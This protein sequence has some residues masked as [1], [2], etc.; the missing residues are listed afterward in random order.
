MNKTKKIWVIIASILLPVV[1]AVGCIVGAIVANGNKDDVKNST[2]DELMFTLNNQISSSSDLTNAIDDMQSLIDKS[3]Y[4]ISLLTYQINGQINK[5]EVIPNGTQV[6]LIDCNDTEKTYFNGWR[7]NGVGQSYNP[8]QVYTVQ[9]STNFVANMVNKA[10]VTFMVDGQVSNTE[11][12]IPGNSTSL[13]QLNDTDTHYFNGW[14][15]DDINVTGRNGKYYTINQDVTV[16]AEFLEHPTVVYQVSGEVVKEEQVNYGTTITLPIQEDTETHYYVGWKING[17][18][19]AYKSYTIKQDITFVLCMSEGDFVKV[20]F[21][22]EG[23]TVGGK[24]DTWTDGT[25]IYCK[26]SFDSKNY[27]LNKETNTWETI[28]LNGLTS[29]FYPSNVWTDGENTYYSDASDQYKLN[30]ET[31]TWEAM[32]WNGLTSFFGT[33]IWTDGENIYHSND[34][35]QYILN[36]ETHTWEAMSWNGLTS[37]HGIYIWTDGE[38]IYY[39]YSYGSVSNQYILKENNTWEEITWE[40][41]NLNHDKAVRGQDIWTDGENIYEGRRY[42]LNENNKWETI[43]WIGYVPYIRDTYYFV[44]SDGVN[45]YFWCDDNDAYYKL[46]R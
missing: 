44:W 31:N 19:E 7:I 12:C 41:E 14:K 15:I 6:T 28:T 27:I 9:Q 1:V 18:G 46:N 38:N 11:Y 40:Y 21:V 2:F 24:I 34:S 5:A 35:S 25:N 26:H 33:S 39:S 23:E 8:N 32:T 30:K 17:L 4:Q 10:V 43:D 37:F 20:D 22:F 45:V 13:P 3:G 42:V 29:S 16:V 36:K